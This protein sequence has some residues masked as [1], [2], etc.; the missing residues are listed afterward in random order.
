MRY[1]L[2]AA[3]LA[4]VIAASPVFAHT[5]FSLSFGITNVA[6][7]RFCHEA[8]LMSVPGSRVY[9]VG[10]VSSGYDVYRYGNLWY[11]SDGDRWYCA[12]GYR[13]YFRPIGVRYV[14]Y[15][16]QF[17]P[18]GYRHQHGRGWQGRGYG[19]YSYGY[20]TRYRNDGVRYR[21][22]YSSRGNSGWNGNDRWAHGGGSNR[23]NQQWNRGN[24][25]W[26]RGDQGRESNGWRQ[27]GDRRWAR[28]DEGRGSRGNWNQNER[29]GR[30]HRADR[31]REDSD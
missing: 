29:G 8:D 26:N 12:N 31:D 9:V 19:A 25:Q 16:V 5:N 11:A 30:G 4:G 14:P 2:C 22:G 10:N 3:V 7:S 27:S 23:G 28:A 1:K 17:V 6:P 24:D 15:N 13:S 18:V 21:G 20:G